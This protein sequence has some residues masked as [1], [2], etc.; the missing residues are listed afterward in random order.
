MTSALYGQLLALGF[1]RSGDIVYRP[2]CPEC[3]ACI[4]VRIPV[5]QFQPN[6]SQR[7]TLQRNSDMN[8]SLN[9][10][11]FTDRHYHLYKQ[12]LGARHSG[13][14]M[15]K[16]AKTDSEAFL[17]A[18]WCNTLLMEITLGE[19][20]VGVAVTD[21]VPDAFSS[22]YTFFSPDFPQR[23]L[24]VFAILKQIEFA[25]EQGL[26]WLYLGYYIEDCRKM[27]YKTNYRPIESLVD[28]TWRLLV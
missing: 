14:D 23:S 28:N 10:G 16:A 2:R 5:A 17:L 26:K 19:Q 22:I 13:G 15:E 1:R 3:S 12:Y 6:R 11:I 4:P 20:L 21:S 7:R 8:I 24:G 27:S 9:E 18:S 25:L